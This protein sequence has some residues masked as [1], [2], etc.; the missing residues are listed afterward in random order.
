MMDSTNNKSASERKTNKKAEQLGAA[1]R[2]AMTPILSAIYEPMT[3]D[4]LKI[5][6]LSKTEMHGLHI[7]CGS[8]EDTF[9]LASQLGENGRISAIDED[10]VMIERARQKKAEKGVNGISFSSA[11]QSTWLNEKKYDFIYTRILM[12]LLLVE[13]S[14][15]QKI[16]QSLK[17]GASL[18]IEGMNLAGYAAYPY[19][20]AFGRSVEI[21]NQLYMT[22]ASD[23]NVKDQLLAMFQHHGFREIKIDFIPPA[24]IDGTYKMIISLTLEAAM[25]EIIHLKLSSTTELNALLLELRLFEKQEDTLISTPGVYQ[26]LAKK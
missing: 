22:H 14:L 16:Y 5:C 12:S 15:L 6:F 18:I 10:R 7:A 19:N 23:Q 3:S 1:A 25:E 24:F 9:L 17:K 11:D 26:I 20:H 21:L 4:F 2:R 8:G 13:E